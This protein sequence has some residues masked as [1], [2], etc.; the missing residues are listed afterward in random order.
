MFD[1]AGALAWSICIVLLLLMDTDRE[2]GKEPN[3]LQTPPT[4]NNMPEATLFRRRVK[5]DRK[6]RHLVQEAEIKAENIDSQLCGAC[7]HKKLRPR[8]LF[9]P[10]MF[11]YNAIE[12]K[13]REVKEQKSQ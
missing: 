6:N 12:E 13:K 3:D 1:K 10:G 5:K 9:T 11:Y 2:G 8:C 4:K 7:E